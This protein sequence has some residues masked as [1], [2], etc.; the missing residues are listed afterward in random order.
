MLNLIRSDLYKAFHMKSF[1]ICGLI[2]LLI[3]G[4]ELLASNDNSVFSIQELI[5]QSGG[6]PLSLM[7]SIFIS[8]FITAE[9]KN[10]YIKNIAGNISDR[11]MLLVSKLV[12][13]IVVIL[14]YFFVQ[15]TIN[16]V[17]YDIFYVVHYDSTTLANCLG[18]SGM[19]LLLN[20]AL[21]TIVVFFCIAAR[22]SGASITMSVL[23]GSTFLAESIVMTFMILQVLQVI[24]EDFDVSKYLVTTY[25]QNFASGYNAEELGI[26]LIV[27][28][29]Y[30]A[31]SVVL[32]AI[33]LKKKDI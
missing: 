31:L 6:V 15:L 9:Y 21:S 1:W 2:P 12:M 18:Q 4:I 22:N 14:L 19:L 7:V 17:L 29:I 33:H 28:G 30:T 27:G 13:S 23:I 25:I 32:S 26:A 24:S 11:V 20:F 3:S 5:G 8:M 10:G 16:V